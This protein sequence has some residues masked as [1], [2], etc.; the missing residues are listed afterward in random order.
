MERLARVPSVVELASEVRNR[1]PVF[2]PE[3]LVVAI[4]QSG[5]TA[6]TL[7]AIRAAKAAGAHVLAVSN[8]VGSALARVADGSLF[9]RA[10]PE[11]GVASTKCFTTQLAALLLLAVYMGR[12]RGSLSRDRAVPLLRALADAPSQMQTV[13]A[14]PDGAQAIGSQLV[15]ATDA[16]FLGRGLGFP[17]A[18]EGAL[19]LKELS[20][21]HAEGYAAGELKHGPIALIDSSRPVVAICPRD[22]Q[23][24]KMVSNM[25]EVLAR[26]GHV[27]AIAT[28]G[29]EAIARL[30]DHVLWIPACNEEVLPL[31]TVLPLQLLAYAVADLRGN[32]VDQ[33]RNLAKSVTV[34]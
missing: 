7:G 6:D 32:D 12:R 29:D 31:L 8:V 15:H 27:I 11:I 18:L 4:S 26:D 14:D 33:P 13:L 17:I 22:G 10:G 2:G 1:S 5:E 30:A 20:Y 16:L 25:Q 19:K 34:E 9:T 28:R 21:T 24:E 23:Y 3:D